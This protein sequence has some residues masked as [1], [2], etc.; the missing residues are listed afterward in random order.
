MRTR[1][2]LPGSGRLVSKKKV[3]NCR[4]QMLFD[5]TSLVRPTRFLLAPSTERE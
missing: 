3:A 1:E 4:K 2:R 5:L